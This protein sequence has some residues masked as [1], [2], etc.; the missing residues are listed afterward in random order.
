[1]E[2]RLTASYCRCHSAS[3]RVPV[4]IWAQVGLQ[5]VVS[6]AELDLGEG[7]SVKVQVGAADGDVLDPLCLCARESAYAFTDPW[8]DDS[9]DHRPGDGR[10][11]QPVRSVHAGEPTRQQVAPWQ[12]VCWLGL[13]H[14][15]LSPEN[16]ANEPPS[17]LGIRW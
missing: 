3:V 13:G 1:M 12:N 5:R 9:A 8:G 7:H 11:N 14:G 2:K 17:S 4:G 10:C 15:L 6:V 16:G